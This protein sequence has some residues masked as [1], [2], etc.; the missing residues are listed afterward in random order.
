MLMHLG[1]R[2][3]CNQWIQIC[4][5]RCNAKETIENPISRRYGRSE[6]SQNSSSRTCWQRRNAHRTVQIVRCQ[7]Y[8][9]S[10]HLALFSKTLLTIQCR[11]ALY[12]NL[13][14][15][16]VWYIF[17]LRSYFIWTSTTHSSCIFFLEEIN[18]I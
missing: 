13:D 4:I 7:A 18:C 17:K 16:Q 14:S 11:T 9:R 8:W 2:V 5:Q 6:L 12:L 1:G 3:K 15:S 10:A